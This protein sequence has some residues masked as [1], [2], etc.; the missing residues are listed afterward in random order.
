MIKYENEPIQPPTTWRGK[1]LTD[2]RSAITGSG[3]GMLNKDQASLLAMRAGKENAS[4]VMQAADE[5]MSADEAIMRGRM[6]MEQ[7]YKELMIERE[8]ISAVELQAVYRASSQEYAQYEAPQLANQNN[9]AD[10]PLMAATGAVVAARALN[11]LKNR[12]DAFADKHHV[13]PRVRRIAYTLMVAGFLLACAAPIIVPNVIETMKP[14]LETAVVAGISTVVE[15]DAGN[16]GAQG[17]T[18]SATK[19]PAKTATSTA[20]ATASATEAAATATETA[21]ALTPRQQEFLTLGYDKLSSLEKGVLYGIMNEKTVSY[22]PDGGIKV[23]GDKT[24]GYAETTVEVSYYDPATKQFKTARF[25]VDWSVQAGPNDFLNYPVDGGGSVGGNPI[26]VSAETLKVWR[27]QYK[28]YTPGDY[29]FIKLMF[30]YD[31]PNA[32]PINTYFD[33][34]FPKFKPG[35][36]PTITI[37][38]KQYLAVRGAVP[39]GYPGWKP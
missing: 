12:F 8:S 15:G 32:S 21:A 9:G 25:V 33:A 14:P 2:A 38:G 31:A 28:T 30:D 7:F 6:A 18:P 4:E 1:D 19:E 29:P 27:D 13:G 20:R 3:T 39:E 34:A 24:D 26:L 36:I 11:G 16:A 10:G 23:E 35:T 17:L 22:M 37:A 5:K